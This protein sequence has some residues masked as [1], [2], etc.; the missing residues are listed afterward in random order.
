M[1]TPRGVSIAPAAADPTVRARVPT[2]KCDDDPMPESTP[3]FER[4]TLEQ[5]RARTSLKWQAM[6]PEVLPLWVAEMDV[7]L[8]PAVVER[9]SAA[10]AAGDTGYPV[11]QEYQRA[12]S[13]FAARH[14]GWEPAPE[15]MTQ[16]ADVMSGMNET[17]LA[18]TE[19]G[20]PV[21]VPTPVYPP[22]LGLVRGTGR[23][24]R[25]VPLTA[26]HRLDLPA[27]R[28]AGAGARGGALLLCNPHNPTGTVHT[29]DE[30]TELAAIAAAHEVFVISDEIHAPLVYGPTPFTPYLQVAPQGRGVCVTSASKTFNLAGLKAA[31]VVAPASAR[32]VPERFSEFAPYGASHLGVLAHSAALREGDEWLAAVNANISHN[33]SF[34]AELFAVRCPQVRIVPGESTYLMWVDARA[35]ALGEDPAHVLRAQGR[36]AFS[37]GPPF[38]LG[39]SGHFRVNLAASRA[40]LTEAVDRVRGVVAAQSS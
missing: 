35:L 11:G 16:V 28:E 24:L 39:G 22:F 15:L 25:E 18:V 38:G 27:L 5:L 7:Q 12:F 29:A 23:Q 14:W 36:V 21:I 17:L 20:D 6:G 3:P 40:V 1:T 31:L 33:R 26:E 9:V 37:A 19:P 8:V 32:D 2:G 34:V 30:L 4:L 10:V 13:Q